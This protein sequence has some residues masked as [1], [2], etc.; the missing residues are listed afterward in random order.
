MSSQD[1]QDLLALLDGSLMIQDGRAQAIDTARL[2]AAIHRLAEVSA[3]EE[4]ARQ[5]LARY[6]TRLAAQA[7]G[8][9]PASIHALYM[10]RGRSE[11]PA[12]FTV[13]AINLC[14]L[15]MDGAQA[16]FRAARS[17]EAGALIFEIAR[18]EMG[19][20]G[21][22]LAEYATNILADAISEA[23]QG[24]V[25]I[26][27]D[28]FQVSAEQYRHD[29]E[30]EMQ[31][32]R[33]L[34]KQAIAAGFFNI[35]VNTSTLVDLSKET[36]PEQQAVNIQLSALLT[37]TV[38][39]LE[40]AGVTISI[41]GE[42]GEVDR[43][44]STVEELH[45]YMDGL[46]RQ[47]RRHNPEAAAIIK[48]SLQTGTTHGGIVLTDGSVD[49]MP[50]ELHQEMYAYLDRTRAKERKPGMTDEQ[51]YYENR[52]YA[53]GPFKADLW[54]LS[55]QEKAVIAQAWEEQ[56]TSLFRRLGLAGT[57][58]YVENTIYPVAPPQLEDYAET[59]GE[60]AASGLSD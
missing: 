27:G 18:S 47:L 4:G 23:Y 43:R 14:V 36:I 17:L 35:D 32:L 29:P 8:I 39:S 51:F 21:Q 25:F 16:V 19:Y 42:I 31:A 12:S 55:P 53:V 6:I 44:N 15:P 52:K 13:P 22:S 33:E 38:R 34:V 5:G 20:T 46:K 60:A 45:A 50:T 3:L 11:I 57:R 59:S 37:E 26:Q 41:G 2:R 56:F 48:I 9:V 49:R 28:H 24:P 54:N 7:V 1:F 10:Q 58:Q 30:I 40:P